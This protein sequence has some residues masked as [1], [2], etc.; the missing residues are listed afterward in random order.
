MLPILT[1]FVALFLLVTPPV[2]NPPGQAIPH[3]MGGGVT[4]IPAFNWTATAW[5]T[6]DVITQQTSSHSVLHTRIMSGGKVAQQFDQ[7][8]DKGAEKVY[9]VLA[10][11]PRGA[12]R[13]RVEYR[14]LRFVQSG[15]S[16]MDGDSPDGAP[17]PSPLAKQTFVLQRDGDA[18]KVLDAHDKPVEQSLAQLVLEEE[19]AHGG[20][21]QRAGD[22][23]ARELS[24]KPINPGDTLDVSHDVARAFVDAHEGFDVVSMQVVL[25]PEVTQE[26]NWVAAFDTHL[27][28]SE[29][30]VHGAAP[31]KIELTGLVRVDVATGRYLSTDLTGSLSIGQATADA[32][33]AVEVVGSGPWKITDRAS[34]ARVP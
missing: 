17:Q 21:L 6:G 30:G 33:R 20:E 1:A 7:T 29:A 10:S 16:A 34:Y 23:L 2:G 8:E 27:T 24:G 15:G 12:T 18:F 26:G 22:L 5:T 3:G 14:R 4:R 11:D 19:S 28:L 32:S 9:T 13:V 31:T 25:M